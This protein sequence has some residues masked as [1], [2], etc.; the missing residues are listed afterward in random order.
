MAADAWDQHLEGWGG[1]FEASLGCVVRLC[2]REKKML[3]KTMKKEFKAL[4]WKRKRVQPDYPVQ[5]TEI[6]CREPE[7]E[8]PDCLTIPSTH[9]QHCSLQPRHGANRSCVSLP[10]LCQDVCNE[11]RRKKRNG[12]CGLGSQKFQGMVFRTWPEAICDGTQSLEE[13]V[14]V[15]REQK[16]RREQEQDRVPKS[17]LQGLVPSS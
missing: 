2:L 15:A 13:H 7:T 16:E 9:P 11:W 1:R 8:P 17:Y 6:S 12:L 5:N 14:V 4:W 3:E 10:P